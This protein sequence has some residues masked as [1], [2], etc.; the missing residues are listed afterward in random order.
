MLAIF[1]IILPCAIFPE[2][3]AGAAVGGP[4]AGLTAHLA[5]AAST[6]RAVDRLRLEH[7]NSPR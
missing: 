5:L 3:C 2:S 7:Y 4:E 6:I 1:A